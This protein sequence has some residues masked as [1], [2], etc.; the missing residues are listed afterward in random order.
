MKLL[1]FLSIFLMVFAAGLNIWSYSLSHRALS[2]VL[3]VFC[4]L[5]G[6]A[7]AY[8]FMTYDERRG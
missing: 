8:L 5:A 4:V 6:I 2:L 7:N 3:A 1:L